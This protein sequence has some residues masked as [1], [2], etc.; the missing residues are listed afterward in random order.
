MDS[1]GQGDGKIGSM[2]YF[3]EN[4]LFYGGRN[5]GECHSGWIFGWHRRVGGQRG[6][7]FCQ[8]DKNTREEWCRRVTGTSPVKLTSFK[9]HLLKTGSRVRRS[10]TTTAR[11]QWTWKCVSPSSSS[12]SSFLTSLLKMW[13]GTLDNPPTPLPC[14]LQIL[15]QLVAFVYESVFE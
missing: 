14:D 7:L 1:F 4:H 10:S 11:I 8:A 2:E 9:A 12:R 5:L 15:Q 13:I 6:L 3:R